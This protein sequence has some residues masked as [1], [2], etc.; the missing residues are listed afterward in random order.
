MNLQNIA[1]INCETDLSFEISTFKAA[2]THKLPLNK[3]D[4]RSAS[5]QII[6]VPPG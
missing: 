3:M 5:H 2:E 6:R 1:R 4:F